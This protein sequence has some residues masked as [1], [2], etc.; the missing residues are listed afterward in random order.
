MQGFSTKSIERI[1]LIGG[2]LTLLTCLLLTLIVQRES[3]HIKVLNE[4]HEL[5]ED[6][7]RTKK[8]VQTSLLDFTLLLS[9]GRPVDESLSTQVNVNSD[10]L[11]HA[12]NRMIRQISTYNQGREKSQKIAVSSVAKNWNRYQRLT[13]TLF[14][15]FENKKKMRVS[16]ALKR[17]RNSANKLTL[18]LQN[19]DDEFLTHIQ[20][21]KSH[22]LKYLVWSRWG[23]MVAVVLYFVLFTVLVGIVVHQIKKEL[24]RHLQ[25]M[26]DDKRV[27]IKEAERKESLW[28]S[29]TVGLKRAVEDV[30][31]WKNQFSA[32]LQSQ[33]QSMEKLKSHVYELLQT[34]DYKRPSTLGLLNDLSALVEE[35]PLPNSPGPQTSRGG[36]HREKM[37]DVL[38][39][40][41]ILSTNAHILASQGRE[42]LPALAHWTHELDKIIE[43]A[44]FLTTEEKEVGSPDHVGSSPHENYLANLKGV[45]RT[46]S[47]YL[48]QTESIVQ[49]GTQSIKNIQGNWETLKGLDLELTPLLEEME[50]RGQNLSHYSHEDRASSAPQKPQPSPQLEES[51]K[52]TSLLNEEGNLPT[53]DENKDFNDRAA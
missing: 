53:N 42:T 46:L 30:S 39:K 38:I 5:L 11:D 41:Q 49:T 24:R 16:R 4:N 18:S 26:D 20:A 19:L 22:G 7:R 35:C 14:D 51:N 13:N 9:S 50:S 15:N 27:L 21:R 1:V 47:R 2:I 23:V 12:Y 37:E 17:V 31:A 33:D 43:E 8:D 29:N 10:K 52:E 44:Q 34:L 25:L 6:I 40:L 45:L 48:H 36:N 28:D 32:S 3:F